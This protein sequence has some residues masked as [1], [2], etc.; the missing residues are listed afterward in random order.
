LVIWLRLGDSVEKKRETL[1]IPIP[2]DDFKRIKRYAEEL[3]LTVN[4]FSRMLLFKGLEW[5]EK[6]FKP[7]WENNIEADNHE[8]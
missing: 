8:E 3:H 2:I 7:N 4:S 5:F 6:S 1:H